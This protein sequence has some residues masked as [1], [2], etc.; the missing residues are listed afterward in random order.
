[1]TEVLV[2]DTE[3]V[4]HALSQGQRSLW[5]LHTMAP[6]SSAYNAGGAGRFRPGPDLPVLTRAVRAVVR[7][8]DMLRSVF[9]ENDGVV[10]R[11]VRDE[12]EHARLRV[13]DLGDAD[14]GEL[15]RAVTA[16]S[17]EPYDL[18]GRGAFRAVLLRRP[19]DAVLLLG[20]HHIASDATSQWL[21]W[22][23]LMDAYEAYAGSGRGPLWYPAHTGYHDH[24][25]REEDLV[26]S[27]R[28][29]RMREYWRS[30]TD[31]A[32]AVQLPLDRPRP[33]APSY[34]GRT[35]ARRV[36]APLTRAVREAAAR[37]G[38]SPFA[39][40]IGAFQVLLHRYTGQHDFTLVCPA[41]TRRRQ[42]AE[43]VGYF[44]NPITVRA[45]FGPA[46]PVTEVI[47]EAAGQLRGGMARAA[48]PY[49]HGAFR[50]SMTMVPAD[51]LG[52][53]MQQVYDHEVE[54]GGRLLSYF[55][56]PHL[57][58]QCDL[59][60]EVTEGADT[61]TVA[62]RYDTDLFEPAT[63]EAMLGHFLTL[64]EDAARRPHEPAG[65]LAMVAADERERLL[66]LGGAR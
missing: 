43:V 59:S 39:H 55:E 3:P 60:V 34:H 57:E 35:V 28:G 47:A 20:T 23:D 1:M 41:S 61:L 17:R 2:N 53:R 62:F 46:T 11:I 13:V 64:T 36:P 63:I 51:R 32:D 38:V 45:R 56:V 15:H 30:V 6:G 42:S 50:V 10:R 4:E 22:R 65:R 44:V 25:A 21:I 66:A 49:E 37:A 5:L 29:A 16:A 24:V 52:G 54:V 27:P 33:A 48:C 9:V 18:S 40:L 26:A 14:D 8:H 19:H 12:R 31:G 7:R 58:G